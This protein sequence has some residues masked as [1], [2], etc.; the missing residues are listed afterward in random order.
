MTNEMIRTVTHPDTGTELDLWMSEEEIIP[1]LSADPVLQAQ[2]KQT[3]RDK[4]AALKVVEAAKQTD[5]NEA[6]GQKVMDAIQS[7]TDDLAAFDNATAAQRLAMQKR[8]MQRQLAIMK[9][10][11]HL[12]G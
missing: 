2:G 12:V 6:R 9:I 1:L 4:V 7:L 5:L 11:A 10:L 8:V 3:I